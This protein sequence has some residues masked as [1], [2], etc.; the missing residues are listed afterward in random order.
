MTRLTPADRAT[1]LIALLCAAL[2]I[3]LAIVLLREHLIVF[4]G[5]VAGGLFCGGAGKFDCNAVAAHP[6][7]WWVGYPV[8]MWG[9]MFYTAMAALALFSLALPP[10]ERAAALELG[11]VLALAA[12]LLD[13]YLGFLMVTRIGAICLNCVASYVLNIVLAVAFW[14]LDRAADASADWRALLLG[15]W[16]LKGTPPP[17]PASIDIPPPGAAAEPVSAVTSRPGRAGK[18]A[19]ALFAIAGIVVTF[20]LTHQRVAETLLDARDEAQDFLN[21][22][23]N[24]TPIDM[25]AFDDRPSEGPRDARIH[26]VVASDFECSYCRA[27]SARLETLR[28]EYPNDLRVTFLHAPI[29][30]DCNPAVKVRYHQHACWLA[31]AAICAAEHGKFWEYHRLVYEQ[32]P[33]PQV[34]EETVRARI[35]SIGIPADGLDRCIASAACDSVLARDVKLYGDLEMKSVPSLIING[36]LKA[37]G[38]YPTTL[39]AVVRA[40]LAEPR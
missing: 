37:G 13:A 27:L 3:A 15:W 16:P 25:A 10:G 18:L 7:S 28:A 6:S 8:A 23:A 19:V 32:I 1:A 11:I 22:Y 20:V 14:R 4:E 38:I 2:G 5:D 21:Q 29:N 24:E 17:T 12:V 26:I 40:L 30:N 36:H 31:K 33:L 9:L 35:A 39:R 34:N